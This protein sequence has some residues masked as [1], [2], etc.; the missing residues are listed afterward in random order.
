LQKL[1]QFVLSYYF[2]EFRLKSK[3][4]PCPLQAFI[5][6]QLYPF[7]NNHIVTNGAKSRIKSSKKRG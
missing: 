4:T 5:T 1:Y 3:V 7:L 2:Q 6:Q